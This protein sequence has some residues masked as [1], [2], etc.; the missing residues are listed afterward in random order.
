M[1]LLQSQAPV[2]WELSGS[3]ASARHGTFDFGHQTSDMGHMNL[4]IFKRSY[5][6]RGH[7]K[8]QAFGLVWFG[9]VWFG[10]VREDLQD[11]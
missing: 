10:M 1:E 7:N 6:Q 5:F 3:S 9:M 4:E 2:D 11:I 8:D